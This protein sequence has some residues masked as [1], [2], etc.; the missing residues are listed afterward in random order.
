MIVIFL[1]RGFWDSLDTCG[2]K[3]MFLNWNLSGRNMVRIDS[4]GEDSPRGPMSPE[5]H[6]VFV[7]LFI[8]SL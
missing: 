1:F 4:A 2:W 7:Y 6:C 3:T 8:V 5:W